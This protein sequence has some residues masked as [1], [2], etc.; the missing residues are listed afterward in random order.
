[1]IFSSKI[2]N[3]YKYSSK[4]K[5]CADCDLI[6]KLINFNHIFKFYKN[7]VSVFRK[8]KDQLSANI[9]EAKIELSSLNFYV[10]PFNFLYKIIN[11]ILNPISYIKRCYINY[12]N[13]DFKI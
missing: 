9:E 11:F 1:M 6:L 8:S 7:N 13:K 3:R 4:L 5:I 10:S 12:V 2:F